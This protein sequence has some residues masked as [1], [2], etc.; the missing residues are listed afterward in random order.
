MRLL[1]FLLFVCMF[2][3]TLACIGSGCVYDRMESQFY[4][5]SARETEMLDSV[6]DL[7]GARGYCESLGL[8]ITPKGSSLWMRA[9]EDEMG[10]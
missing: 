10:I 2:S 5:I 9:L 7:G 1:T 4:W 8:A 3:F 6:R